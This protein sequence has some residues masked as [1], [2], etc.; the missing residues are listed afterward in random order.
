MPRLFL[1]WAMAEE[2]GERVAEKVSAA[3][4]GMAML[5]RWDSWSEG[6]LLVQ[7]PTHL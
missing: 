3:E 5:T 2:E 4:W 1:D 7:P 6:N